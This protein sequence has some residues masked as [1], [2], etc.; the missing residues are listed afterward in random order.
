M[1]FEVAA[2]LES[3]PEPD[4]PIEEPVVIRP[5]PDED[6]FSISREGDGW[7]VKGKRIER[8]AAMTYWEFE[9]TTRRFQQ[10]L[11]TT[12]I[13]SALL[14]AGINDGDMVFIGEEVLEWSE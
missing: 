3:A 7:R 14:E 9:A 13:S 12:G 1:L 6:A 4:M 5:M 8:L 11:E 2:M 10:I